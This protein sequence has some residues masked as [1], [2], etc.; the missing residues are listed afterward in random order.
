MEMGMRVSLVQQKRHC[1]WAYGWVADHES[2]EPG[3]WHSKKVADHESSEP[4]NN[5]IEITHGKKV[6]DHE[7]A[8]QKRN[9][10]WAYGWV[11]DHESSEPGAWHSKRVADNESEPGT[12]IKRDWNESEPGSAK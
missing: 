2:S 5:K 6:A 8:Q 10:T 4:G 7:M 11:A 3:A 12:A 9:Y 1:T